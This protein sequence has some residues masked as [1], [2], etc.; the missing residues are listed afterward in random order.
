MA[1]VS[2][3]IPAYNAVRYLGAAI[4]SALGQTIRDIE[5]IVVDDG[6]NDGT[7]EAVARYGASVRYL[8]QS[9]SGVAVARNHGVERSRS[10]YVAFLDADDAWLPHKLETQLAAM[11]A[12]PMRRA[13]YSTFILADIDLKPI[14]VH[15]SPRRGALLE[16]LLLIGNVVGTPTTV[17][18]ERALL[19][20]SGGFDPALS[21]CADWEMWIRLSQSSDFA[22]VKQPLALYRQHSANMSRDLKLYE[23]DAMLVLD[24]IFSGTRLSE[25]LKAQRR[26][27]YGHMRTVLAGSYLHAFHLR[28]FLRCAVSAVVLDWRQLG[29]FAGFPLRRAIGVLARDR[30]R[31]DQIDQRDDRRQA[32]GKDD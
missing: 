14:R 22:Y 12:K 9:N 15:E 10:E 23:R 21:L 4:E 7:E 29:Y 6:S 16:D 5:I 11:R 19:N 27:S 8:R 3:V 13:C 31:Y 28:D 18:C 2:V 32:T 17:V 1:L 24:K 20:A 25:P 30:A 26:R